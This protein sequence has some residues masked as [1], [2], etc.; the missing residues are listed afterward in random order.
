MFASVTRLRVRS[1]RYLP[2]FLWQTFL[3]QRQAQRTP[4]FLGGRLLIDAHSTYWTLTAWE[5]ERAMKVFRGA[6]P[7]VR[8]MPR[9]VKLCDEAS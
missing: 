3:I 8:V 1:M 9:L 7:H 4:G 2:S 6:A 5:T